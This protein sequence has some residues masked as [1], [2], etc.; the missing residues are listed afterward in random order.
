MPTKKTVGV[1]LLLLV[2]I[3]GGYVW[4]QAG[5]YAS[6]VDAANAGTRAISTGKAFARKVIPV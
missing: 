3:A 1:R 6:E 5:Q 2:A 4:Q